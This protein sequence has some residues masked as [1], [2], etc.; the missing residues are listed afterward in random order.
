MCPTGTDAVEFGQVTGLG[1]SAP[2]K[3]L[4]KS[5]GGSYRY[6]DVNS[7]SR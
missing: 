7:F 6:I 1:G 3:L 2:L 4:A 5:T